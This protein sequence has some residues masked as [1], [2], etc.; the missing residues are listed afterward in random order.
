MPQAVHSE[1]VD[2][3]KRKRCEDAFVVEKNISEGKIGVLDKTSASA[4]GD[5]AVIELYDAAMFDA[6][7]TD[8]SRLVKRLINDGIPFILPAVIILK[9]FDSK[10]VERDKAILMLN[11]LAPFISDDEYA[12]TYALIERMP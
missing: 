7:G 1:V 3:G 9:M 12:M 5:D 10:H 2:A 11:Q 4:K 8:D 6:V